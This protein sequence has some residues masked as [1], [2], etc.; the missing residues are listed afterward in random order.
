VQHA[1]QFHHAG[2]PFVFDPG[3]GLP[4]FDGEA[5]KHFLTQAQWVT[6]NDYEGAMLTE[7]TG[8]SSAEIS[9]QV[10]GGLIVT[11]G[12]AGSEVW[13]NGE[14]TLVPVVVPWCLALWS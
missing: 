7:R 9:R 3:Q 5:L 6:V 1:E 11:L 4:M 10:P 12:A 8:L 14:K 13:V 2:I